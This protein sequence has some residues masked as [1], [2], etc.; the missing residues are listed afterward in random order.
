MKN[1]VYTLLSIALFYGCKNNQ[2]EIPI[3]ADIPFKPYLSSYTTGVISKS[4]KINIIFKENLSD[5]LLE[6]TNN[7]Y[8]AI[9]LEPEI[10]YRIQNITKK[11]IIITPNEPFKSGTRYR[12]SVNVAKLVNKE[13]D[14]EVFPLVFETKVQDYSIHELK[15]EVKDIYKPNEL[16]VSGFV[17]T[18]DNAELED[19]KKLLTSAGRYDT[20]DVQWIKY[21]DRKFQFTLP[22]ITKQKK[23]TSI[24]L[25]FNGKAFNVNHKENPTLDI[26]AVSDFKMMKWDYTSYPDQILTLEFSE[27]LEPGQNLKGL[28]Q[29]DAIKRF[30]YETEKN[31][32]KLFLKNSFTGNTRLVLNRGIKAF[33]GNKMKTTQTAQV[34]IDRPLA[35]VEM[36]GDGNIL[37]NSQGLIVPFKTI[38]LKKVDVDIFKIH[39][40]NILQFL[41]VNEIS[42]NSQ[43]RRVAEKIKTHTINLASSNA[44]KLKQW[45]THGVNLR[46]IINPEPGAIYR[47]R[48]S[49]KQAYTFCECDNNLNNSTYSDYHD[50]Y[51]N[52]NYRNRENYDECN[53]YFYYYSTKSKNLLASDLG[54]IA[55]SG[56]NKKYDVTTTNL[57]NGN[58]EGYASLRFYNYSQNLIRSVSTDDRGFARV[59]L[60]ESPFAVIAS[61]GQHKAYLK[62]GR[63]QSNS[64]SKFETQGV[65]RSAGVDAFFYGERGVWRP[66]DDIHLSCVIRDE[67]GKMRDGQPMKLS[68][69]NPNG[70]LVSTKTIKLTTSGIHSVLLKTDASAP[71]GNYQVKL[72]AGS[73]T[74]YKTLKIETVRPNRLKIVIN[75][76]N[77][78]ILSTDEELK[79]NSAWL[80][81]AKAGGLKANVV[82]KLSP[83][84][85]RFE[86]H[87][88]YHFQ[89]VAKSFSSSEKVI[90]DKKLDSDGN[91]DIKLPDLKIKSS[92]KL[93]ASF[94]TKVFEKGGGFSIDQFSTTFHPY[95]SYVG[96]D[97]PISNYGYLQTNK[98]NSID[99]VN[100]NTKGNLINSSAKLKVKVYKIEWRWWWQ[101]NEEDLAS[102]INNNSYDLLQE[103]TIN[104]TNGRAS[105]KLNIPEHKWGQYYIQI[106]DIASG[107]STGSSFFADYYGSNRN[108]KQ[109]NNAL[110]L[111]MKMDK[112]K[113]ETGEL[114]NLTFPRSQFA[115]TAYCL[116]PY[117]IKTLY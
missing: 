53:E 111:K 91:A 14:Q 94:I 109:Q 86:K 32:V 16:I 23:A 11:H 47:V 22:K 44:R 98:T 116:L 76:E 6:D 71:T 84:A 21:T 61:S 35:T 64:L 26:A 69:S 57:I 110:L 95:K 10:D 105:Y 75:T 41:Q 46:D 77:D 36:I 115:C 92:G 7:L 103:K 101:H 72:Q 4:D 58:A 62:L 65:M 28:I 54:L 102:Y 83:T 79:L 9:T 8:A 2:I 85:T 39:E 80:H 100:V 5:S 78:E 12:A 67:F 87:K 82:M 24:A 15:S 17:K 43:M 88:N 68:F 52:S 33:S 42:E 51:E 99:I 45:T 93:R 60:E 81:G 19:I 34:T 25:A 108:Q 30:T 18:T 73:H 107:H 96:M 117:L 27:P 104:T 113:Y 89:D 50:Y 66:G 70:Q 97:I 13:L 74:F 20:D 90:F 63:N 1:L 59:S 40:K 29:L 3:D 38:G 48:F 56:D 112:E 49:F 114:A 31:T 37:P 55:K 106:T